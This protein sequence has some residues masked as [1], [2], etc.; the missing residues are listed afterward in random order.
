MVDPTGVMRCAE[1]PAGHARRLL[2]PFGLEAVEVANHR[3]IPGSYWGAPEA[4]LVGHR[5][6]FRVDTPVHSLLHEA[7]HYICMDDGRRARL[8]TDAAG[9]FMEESA[10]CYL[11]VLLAD[12]V[13]GL[14][15]RRLLA[16]MDRWGYS[17]RLGSARAWFEKDAEDARHWLVTH[18][19]IDTA[20]RL[21]EPSRHDGRGF[22]ISEISDTGIVLSFE[23]KQL[24]I[25]QRVPQQ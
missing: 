11:Q 19:I 21:L 14:G 10:V 25:V 20:D 12:A 7:C 18:G 2:A 17:F 5:L 6:L 23:H 3:P 8:H 9:D 15:R 24:E 13:P 4:G 16:D 1:L 22:P